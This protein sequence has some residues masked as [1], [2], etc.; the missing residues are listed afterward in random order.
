MDFQNE[1]QMK[2][3][4]GL[5]D[6]QAQ[7]QPAEQTAPAAETEAVQEQAYGAPEQTYD[8]PAQTYD[9]PAQTYRAPEQA[10]GTPEQTYHAPAQTD[11]APE[12]TCPPQQP[13]YP[14]A[15]YTNQTGY[16]T[17]TYAQ[18]QPKAKP[19]AKKHKHLGLKVAALALA[20]ALLGSIG[21]GTVVGYLLRNQTAATTAATEKEEAAK[22]EK[23]VTNEEF[24]AAMT[25]NSTD[26]YMTPAQIYANYVDA[27]VGI[28]N[29]STVTNAYGQISATASSGTGFIITEDGYV[30]TNYH[31][32][33]DATTLTVTLHDGTEYDAQV[34][35]YDSGNDVALLKINATGL[36]VAPLG[37]S[38]E[39]SVGDE[40]AAIGNPLGELDFSMTVGYISA[41]DRVI[42]TDGTP[43]N[44]M[45]T[46]VAINSGNSGGPLFDMHGNVVGI[47]TAKYS[48]ST[49]SGTTIEG[50][51][52]A[53]PINDV[54][55]IVL[56]LQQ[57]GYVTGKPYMGVG[58]RDI[59][60][61]YLQ[62]YNYPSSAYV[63]S[64]E[65]GSS[66]ETAGVKAGDIITAIGEEQ[67]ASYTD[68]VT[69]LTKFSAGDTTTITV[70]RNGTEQTLTIT[71]DERTPQSGTSSTTEVQEPTTDTTDET[72]PDF[73]FG[74]LIP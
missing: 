39:L 11:S 35:G 55:T 63:E 4:Q 69:A 59:D 2:P 46:D 67:V 14:S 26:G 18:P 51:G 54:K 49:T 74:H 50:L 52:F 62:Y 65:Q 33:E 28:A 66:A 29:E 22:T 37:D 71:F 15:A 68:L 72:T 45:Q 56:D 47:T 44:M 13:V 3:E 38:D 40:V 70:Y 19:R 21:G 34:V 42:N 48:G 64:V 1:E 6:T 43:I 32:I 12:N 27:V 5:H 53:I 17:P 16:Q 73:G 9:A 36:T 8:A 7:T 25:S 60:S 20:C 41:L 30:V 23:T 24:Q 31:V 61:S 10:Y 58:V 57:Y